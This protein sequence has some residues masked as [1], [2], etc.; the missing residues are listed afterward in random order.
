MPA[1]LRAVRDKLH[2]L[3]FQLV[4]SSLCRPIPRS[5][6]DA[7][8]VCEHT[9]KRRFPS[10]MLD[11]IYSK[12]TLGN[13]AVAI[14]SGLLAASANS[15]GGPRSPFNLAILVLV[16][17]ALCIRLNW[18]ENY[19]GD[20]IAAAGYQAPEE[21]AAEHLG[22]WR[23]V[24][25]SAFGQLTEVC[26]TFRDHPHVWWCG[27][28]QSLFESAMYIFVLLWTPSLPSSM[29][30]GITFAAFMSAIMLGSRISLFVPLVAGSVH[31]W[32]GYSPP[33]PATAAAAA[34]EVRLATL[35]VVA[36]NALGAVCLGVAALSTWHVGPVRSS[37]NVVS[38]EI[39][40][41]SDQATSI[42]SDSLALWRLAAYCGFEVCCGMHFTSFYSLRGRYILPENG[43]TT[44]LNIYRVPLN[45]IVLTVCLTWSSFSLHWVQLL[46]MSI[47]LTATALSLVIHFRLS[48]LLAS[49]VPSATERTEA[50]Q[51]AKAIE[52]D[53]DAAT[54]TNYSSQTFV[55][56]FD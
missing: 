16:V 10:N 9:T 47:L 1:I 36:Y 54:L 3:Q 38:N 34:A 28:V 15:W 48:G 29:D 43:R 30:R 37:T 21:S 39:A 20:F 35:P 32:L 33:A 12:A 51:N 44:I 55:S 14:L 8:M 53:K 2:T 11:R 17:C 6:F 24:C 45:V 4:A 41:E 50:G 19:G 18:S 7:W 46:C 23:Q 25:D 49:A 40:L 31:R 22:F 42:I 5:A 56:H 26:K 27:I 13:G 52:Q